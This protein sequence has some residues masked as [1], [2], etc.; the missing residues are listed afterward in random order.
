MSRIRDPEH[1]RG[2]LLDAATA[3]VRRKGFQAASLGDI[4]ATAGVTKGALYHHF[5]DKT[6]LGYAVLEERITGTIV[7][8]WAEPLDADGNP[9]D[10]LLAVVAE[11]TAVLD[12]DDIALGC[13][14]NNLALEMSP[15]DEGFRERINDLYVAWYTALALALAR[16]QDE[17]TVRADVD[18]AAAAVFVVGALAGARSM[19]KHAQSADV[20]HSSTAC[21][22]EYIEG[23]R[24]RPSVRRV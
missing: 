11:S 2:V 17:G 22:T 4:L 3:E 7:G 5:E 13:P 6:A 10:T 16:G 19:A 15:V 12:D 18:P 21:L 8:T 14:L 24:A 1:T 23:L 9:V 20:L